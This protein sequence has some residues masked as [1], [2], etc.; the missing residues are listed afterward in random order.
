MSFS[1]SRECAPGQKECADAIALTNNL[2]HSLDQA[3]MD[4]MSHRL[5]VQDEKTESGF[6][7]QLCSAAREIKD[8]VDGLQ[9]AA[10]DTESGRSLGTEVSEL[11][12]YLQPLSDSAIGAA[13]RSAISANQTTLLEQTKT[14]L[15][16]MLQVG[17]RVLALFQCVFFS[18]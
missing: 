5:R 10:K 15:E 7:Q 11:R 14:I 13:S 3:H 4:A 6:Q 1:L 12:C 2:I 17:A 18:S 9:A 16:A 8:R